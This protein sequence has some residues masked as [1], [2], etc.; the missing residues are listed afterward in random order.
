MKTTKLI[1]KIAVVILLAIS[2]TNCTTQKVVV[3]GIPKTWRTNHLTGVV[4]FSYGEI[5]N[6][7]TKGFFTSGVKHGTYGQFGKGCV[8]NGVAVDDL[9]GRF[10]GSHCNMT[11]NQLFPKGYYRR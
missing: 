7:K 11:D 5:Q 9:K 10:D 3:N 6:L 2:F 8:T 4:T 1:S